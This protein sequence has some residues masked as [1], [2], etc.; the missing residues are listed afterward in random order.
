MTSYRYPTE[1]W[2]LVVSIGLLLLVIAAT[3]VITFHTSIL[4]IGLAVS[5]AYITGRAQHQMLIHKAFKIDERQTPELWGITRQCEALLKTTST[6]YFVTRNSALNAYTFGLSSPQV[7]VLYSSLFQVM[8]Q[9]ELRFIIGHELGHIALGHTWLNTLVGGMAGIPGASI[10]SAVLRL[11]FLSWN[12]ACELS[13][14]RAGLLACGR[15]EKAITALIKLVAGP[16]GHTQ[17]GLELAYHQID[18]EDDTVWG[19]L[20]EALG[21]HPMLIRRITELRRFAASN[22]YRRLYE[23]VNRRM[24]K[25][26]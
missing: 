24:Q 15:P 13:A 7:V 11:A 17:A 5:L 14:D 25:A 1:H 23:A 22:Q 19:S 9:D 2:I 6:E 18:A 12:R 8:D 26:G 21:T 10:L 20:N 4:I 3:A 16:T